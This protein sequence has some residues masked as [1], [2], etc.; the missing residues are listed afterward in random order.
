[1]KNICKIK[2]GCV[3]RQFCGLT[4]ACCFLYFYSLEAK[5][6]PAQTER[7]RYSELKYQANKNTIT[8]V[9][10]GASTTQI[11]F[12]TDLADVLNTQKSQNKERQ[13]LRV[14]PVIGEGGSQNA[15]DILYLRGVD[16]G[17]VQTDALAYLRG[18]DPVLYKNIQEKIHY[19][20]KLYN[21]E[22]HVI[23]NKNI[24][25]LS[26]L[27]GKTVNVSKK[28][29]GTYIASKTIFE[30]L[31]IKV[32]YITHDDNVA[33]KM[34]QN[35]KVDAVAI[36]AGVPVTQIQNIPADSGLHFVPVDFFFQPAHKVPFK[37]VLEHFYLPTKL[38]ASTYPNLIPEGKKV[39]TIASS[40]ILAVYNWPKGSARHRKTSNFIKMFFKK[41]NDFNR[42]GRHPKWEEVNLSAT[43]PFWQRYK[44]ADE[45]LK[46]LF[47]SK[48][49][50]KN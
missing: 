2:N 49:Q 28:F 48:N 40:T 43:P 8:I 12:A 14:I 45:Q 25:K 42:P 38:Q 15:L 30:L 10:G 16:M 5:A 31:G 36:L 7:T 29:S 11:Q 47:K 35:G 9:T 13:S 39:G 23:S 6:E 34:L 19:I 3:F 17:I 21:S 1:M 26:D 50:S 44:P 46:K 4:I 33:L 24:Q 37:F 32:N 20:T 22:W 27:K 41:F 18:Q